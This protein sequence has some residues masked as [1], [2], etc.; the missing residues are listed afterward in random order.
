MRKLDKCDSM[1]WIFV[2]G[3]LLFSFSSAGII[4][5]YIAG[6]A[7][8]KREYAQCP[9][10]PEPLLSSVLNLDGST[11]CVYATHSRWTSKRTKRIK[12]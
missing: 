10:Q 9:P 12:K 2:V 11:L 5:A 6:H 7:E 1:F 3:L 4:V 8:G